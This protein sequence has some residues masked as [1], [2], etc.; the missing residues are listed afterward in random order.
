MEYKIMFSV[1]APMQFYF[2]RRESDRR[3]E[4]G[5]E[6][7]E[8]RACRVSWLLARCNFCCGCSNF[9]TLITSFS[10][11]SEHGARFYVN[12]VFGHVHPLEVRWSSLKGQTAIYS[13]RGRKLI[14]DDLTL[15]LH[16]SRASINTREWIQSY[17]L[18]ISDFIKKLLRAAPVSWISRERVLCW[19]RCA[20]W[21][22]KSSR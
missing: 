8:M 10:R 11:P 20:I 7:S 14:R 13:K 12:P 19:V 21:L 17:L 16:A 18:F 2:S 9:E 3:R 4:R 15:L 1:I 22:L 6:E 5:R